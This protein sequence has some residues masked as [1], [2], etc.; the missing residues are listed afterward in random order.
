LNKF[1][2]E[3]RTGLREG[4]VVTSS[5]VAESIESEEV[6]I[7]LRR[8]LE[9][10]GISASVLEESHDYICNW[11][12]GAIANGM[13]EEMDPTARASLKG[14]IDSGYGGSTGSS[15]T[16]SI[17]PIAVANEGFENEIAQHPSRIPSEIS[18]PLPRSEGRIRKASIVSSVIFKLLKK[19][20]AIIQ[21]SS[22]GDLAK[23]S[24]LIS[25]GANV[26]ARDR[27]GVSSPF[28]F[29]I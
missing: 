14:S 22:D 29:P 18:E 9:D 21:A 4:S 11:L 19:D 15:Y 26:N 6:W 13:L 28:V 17:V 12:K 7:R 2:E 8:E 3:V 20:T 10:V 27:W 25:Q 5:D 23:V 16:P 1:I 24:K